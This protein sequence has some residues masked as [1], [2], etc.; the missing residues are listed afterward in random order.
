MLGRMSSMFSRRAGPRVAA[1]ALAVSKP[2]SAG[3]SSARGIVPGATLQ[4]SRAYFEF[5]NSQQYLQHWTENQQLQEWVSERIELFQPAR[6]HLC[7]GSDQ[8]NKELINLMVQQGTLIKLNPELRPNSYLARSTQSDVARVEERTYICSDQKEDAGPT[9][10]WND[11][12]EMVTHMTKLYTGAMNGRTMY[13][14]PFCMGP[15][16]SPMAQLGVQVT[17]S[18]YVVASMR[19]MTRMGKQ[20]MERLNDAGAN[21][22]PCVHTVGQPL[23]KN[24]EDKP[25]PCNSEKYIVHFPEQRRIWSYGSG[26]GGN[27]MLGKKCMALRIASAM[28]RDEGWLAEHMLIVGITN[29]E[30]VKKFFAAAF[31]SACGK[32]NLAMMLPNAEGWKVECVGDDIAWM[33]INPDDGKLYAINPEAGFF[34]VAPGTSMDTNPNAMLGLAEN[35]IFTNTA[36]TRDGDIWWEGMTKER[37]KQVVSWLRTE[38]TPA[39]RGD[40][41]HPNSRFCSPA[42]QCPVIDPLWESPGGVPI[43]GII[44]GGRRSDCVPLVY[45]ARDWE[46]GVFMGATMSSETTAAAA[47]KRGVLRHDPFAMKP[48]CGYN[49]ADYFGHWLS[50]KERTEEKKLP[51]IFHVNWF[52]KNK[53]GRFL[54]PGFGDNI[55]VLEWLFNRSDKEGLCSDSMDS[56]IGIMPREGAINT[57]GLDLN[58]DDME[59]LMKLDKQQ[60]KLETKKHADFFNTFGDRM[61]EA[62]H[63]QMDKLEKN[64]DNLEY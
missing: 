52:K 12:Q 57:D 16:D 54:W 15:I 28:A 31:P 38:M 45:E 32:T 6:V 36:I 30:G 58:K 51:K 17:D 2:L 18:P 44:F 33:H 43:S 4:S 49:M 7:D 19:V 40:A 22:V 61:P 39:D 8:E 53:A 20:V 11:P 37:P 41:A 13:V 5:V 63:S 34:G 47:G 46:H 56:A 48:F 35:T 29:P 59:E 60:W 9:N 3:R 10:H 27:S 42:A 23:G 1:R 24:E 26:Y 21:F 64:I 25:W 55:K 50:F 62:M 14:I